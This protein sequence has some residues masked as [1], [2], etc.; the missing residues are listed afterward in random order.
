M[1]L[2][3]KRDNSGEYVSVIDG[4]SDSYCTP[5]SQYP[6]ETISL[7]GDENFYKNSN[8]DRKSTV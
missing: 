2:L 4:S 5:L 8:G 3:V 7:S 6:G 1:N